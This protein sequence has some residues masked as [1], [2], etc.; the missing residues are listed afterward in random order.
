MRADIFPRDVYGSLRIKFALPESTNRRVRIPQSPLAHC[1]AKDVG[2]SFRE[3]G[4][5]D[6][7]LTVNRMQKRDHMPNP[8]WMQRY[9]YGENGGR[10][11]KSDGLLKE[12]RTKN[13]NSKSKDGLTRQRYV[14]DLY[15]YTCISPHA[16]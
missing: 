14:N 11:S 2:E 16:S 1:N 7:R 3:L 8:F 4:T 12:T 5:R 10:R 6:L 9:S 15:I 13:Q